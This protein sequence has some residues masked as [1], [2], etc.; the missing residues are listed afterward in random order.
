VSKKVGMLE[1][2]ELRDIWEHEAKDFTTWLAENLDVLDSQLSELELELELDQTEKSIGSFSADILATAKGNSLV[3][4]EN[5]L[6]DTNHKHLGQILTYAINAKA[7]AVLWISPKPRPEHTAVM[8]WLSNHTPID[9]HLV[10]VQ[11]FK[12]GESD[13]APL[14][15]LVSGSDEVTKGGAKITEDLSKKQKKHVKFLNQL[16]EKS[17]EVNNIFSNVSGTPASWISATTG[18]PGTK[19]NFVIMASKARVRLVFKARSMLEKDL[20]TN[21]K[22]F[23]KVIAK[24]DEIET[25]FGKK[26]IWDFK[27][28]RRHQHVDI[29][30]NK[31][32]LHDEDKWDEIQN[33]MVET[34]DKFSKALLPYVKK[35]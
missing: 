19:F 22:R 30:V 4:I 6:T 16:I 20:A 1:P 26:L 14:F 35:L 18:I 7:D 31:G 21:D 17:N 3:V 33:S 2:V 28:G 29:M 12:I 27:E 9:F 34:M 5:Q 13:S 24:K 25:A 23:E 32:G 10:K 8:N 11:A 15:T